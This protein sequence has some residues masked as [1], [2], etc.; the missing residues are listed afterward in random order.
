MIFIGTFDPVISGIAY[1]ALKIAPPFSFL[2]QMKCI[3]IEMYY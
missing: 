2:F 3:I 1:S